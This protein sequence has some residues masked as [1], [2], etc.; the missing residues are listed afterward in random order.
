MLKVGDIVKVKGTKHVTKI[1]EV[2]ENGNVFKLEKMAPRGSGCNCY[3]KGELT[4]LVFTA[5]EVI[6]GIE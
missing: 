1:I 4:K 5:V 3:H 2:S 6:N